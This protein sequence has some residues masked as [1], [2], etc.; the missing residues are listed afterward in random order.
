MIELCTKRRMILAI[1]ILGGLSILVIILES[2]H[3]HTPDEAEAHDIHDHHP[4]LKELL[5]PDDKCWKT[6]PF[7]VVEPCDL[8]SEIE[9]ANKSPVVCVAKGKKELVECTTAM[10]RTY[11]SCDVV[12]WIEERRFWTFEGLL[13][14]FGFCSAMTVF[15]RQKQLDHRMYQRIQRQIAAGV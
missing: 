8:C 11:R 15:V 13:S 1:A 9:I 12:P 2:R 7:Q 3:L 6:E 14:F 5:S 10:K 4:I